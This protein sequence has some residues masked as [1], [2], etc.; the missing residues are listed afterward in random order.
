PPSPPKQDGLAMPK[1]ECRSPA[2][3]LG[4]SLAWK[5]VTQAQR[6]LA[7]VGQ[8]LLAGGVVAKIVGVPPGSELGAPGALAGVGA[9]LLRTCFF[10]RR[11]MTCGCQPSLAGM[12]ACSIIGEAPRLCHTS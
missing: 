6:A 12:P 11:R 2:F 8:P 5:L 3:G 10:R 7:R 9:N 1:P 4:S